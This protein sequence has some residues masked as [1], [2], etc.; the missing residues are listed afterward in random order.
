MPT[1]T[2]TTTQ[3]RHP[4]RATART[5]FAASVGAL[6]LLPTVA[7]AAGVD[8]V[9]L[10]AQAVGVASAVTRVLALPGVDAWLRTYAPFLASAPAAAGP[11]TG[12]SHRGG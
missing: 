8:T 9:P 7:I 6:S 1:P 4:W 11:D 12:G 10:V 2:P 3:I 5:L